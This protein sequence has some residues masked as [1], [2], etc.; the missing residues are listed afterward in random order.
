MKL[1]SVDFSPIWPVG[2]CLIIKAESLEQAIR[3]AG[4]TI[5]HTDEFKVKEVSMETIGVVVYLS[6]DY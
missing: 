6:G 3:I 1:F 2:G 4:D 5:G